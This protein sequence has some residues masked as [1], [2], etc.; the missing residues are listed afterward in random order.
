M[1]LKHNPLYRVIKGSLSHRYKKIPGKMII[2]DLPT[3]CWPRIFFSAVIGE[4]SSTPFM[5]NG[6]S[7][8]K[9]LN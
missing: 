5:G 2:E 3:K 9:H 4:G 8:Y 1:N 7:S 6:K